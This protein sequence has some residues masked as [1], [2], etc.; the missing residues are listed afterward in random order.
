MEVGGKLWK[1][2][3]NWA[4]PAPTTAQFFVVHIWDETSEKTSPFKADFAGL[5]EVHEI[6]VPAALMIFR[7]SGQYAQISLFTP[8][9]LRENILQF[10]S[11]LAGPPPVSLAHSL[12]IG[13]S[14]CHVYANATL[15]ALYQ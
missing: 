1:H 10:A 4:S 5:A 12:T 2:L 3:S 11:L 9:E 14:K 13:L 7:D 8:M 6:S 15:L